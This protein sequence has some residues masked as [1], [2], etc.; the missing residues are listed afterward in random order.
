MTTVRIF[1][2]EG[3]SEFDIQASDGRMTDVLDSS[4]T[5]QLRPSEASGHPEQWTTVELD[6]ILIV[7]PPAQ[8]TDRM[9]RLHRPGQAVVIR[10]GPYTVAGASHVPAGTDAAAFLLRHRQHFVPITQATITHADGS[11]AFTELVAI[12]NLWRAESLRAP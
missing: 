10:L 4:Q 12:V 1:T 11:S 8:P 9:R 6:E 2:A 3:A 7:I 5:L